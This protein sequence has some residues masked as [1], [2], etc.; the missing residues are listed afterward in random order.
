MKNLLLVSSGVIFVSTGEVEVFFR[1][2]GGDVYVNRESGLGWKLSTRI[3]VN[4]LIDLLEYEEVCVCNLDNYTD[5][6]ALDNLAVTTE[7]P[8]IFEPFH[9]FEPFDNE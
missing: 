2:R 9:V 4:E 8:D 1:V 6:R 7:Y 5:K 3:S